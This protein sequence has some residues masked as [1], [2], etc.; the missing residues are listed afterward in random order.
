[1]LMAAL[2]VLSLL[3]VILYAAIGG[4]E[5]LIIRWDVARVCEAAQQG[6]TQWHARDFVIF[7]KTWIRPG[8][9]AASAR[10]SI[11]ADSRLMAQAPE[12]TFFENIT[13]Y[14]EWRLAGALVST[15]S[16]WPSPWTVWKTTSRSAS[17]KR[18]AG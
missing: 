6:K 4:L 11:Q 2:V 1:M 12:A 16:A 7:W 13:G 18:S 3:G 5:K 8:S 10:R 14:P 15:R 9:C 17:R